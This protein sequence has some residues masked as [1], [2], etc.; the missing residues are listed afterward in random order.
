MQ[1]V[2]RIS[3]GKWE[4]EFRQI[5][6]CSPRHLFSDAGNNEIRDSPFGYDISSP[7]HNVYATKC[8]LPRSKDISPRTHK[9]GKQKARHL[10]RTWWHQPEQPWSK[11][12]DA[13]ACSHAQVALEGDLVLLQRPQVVA[14]I[15]TVVIITWHF[16]LFIV[17]GMTFLQP[18]EQDSK[19]PRSTRQ[20][21]KRGRG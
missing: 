3:M 6:G 21:S 14:V 15:L 19:V 2:G 7:A 5:H 10:A 9:K 13:A 18:V 8:R 17:R 16:E 1:Q 12:G 11:S 4:M 20:M